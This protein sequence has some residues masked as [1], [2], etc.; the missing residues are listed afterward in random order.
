[1]TIRWTKPVAAE[2]ALE[3]ARKYAVEGSS[4]GV[5]IDCTYELTRTQLEA[6]KEP[7][8]DF[9]SLLQKVRREK[10]DERTM[11]H[12]L[13]M[14]AVSENNA[15]KC[16]QLLDEAYKLDK[17]RAQFVL[18]VLLADI[19][20]ATEAHLLCAKY[21]IE[22]APALS[23]R[24]R[25]AMSVFTHMPKGSN[26]KELD[27]CG[28][29]L[30]KGSQF[31]TDPDIFNTLTAVFADHGQTDRANAALKLANRFALAS[32]ADLPSRA[33]IFVQIAD[34][35]NERKWYR[36]TI[37][38]ADA[39]LSRAIEPTDEIYKGTTLQR[40][41]Q[42]CSFLGKEKEQLIWYDRALPLLKS[43]PGYAGLLDERNKLAKKLGQNHGK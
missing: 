3:A 12:A 23:A 30:A 26:K 42:A 27:W 9:A 15:P 4:I 13:V 40:A 38:L 18:S 34:K 28:S 29:L 21:F 31:S 14:N 5:E 19:H 35:N 25:G 36:D 6:G 7:N 32:P 10:A 8:F 37:N 41:G 1:M 16:K 24:G 20:K 17:Q 33:Q 39:E 43:H 2:K 22:H 11:V